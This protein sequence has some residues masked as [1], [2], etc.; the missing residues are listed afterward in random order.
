MMVN[1]VQTS[2]DRLLLFEKSEYLWQ[3]CWHL[4]TGNT[5]I[6]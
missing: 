5:K 1:A 2:I 6:M 4:I 3:A